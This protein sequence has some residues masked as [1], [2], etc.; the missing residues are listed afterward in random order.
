MEL[1]R[2][3]SPDEAKLILTYHDEINLS[4]GFIEGCYLTI[5]P[6]LLAMILE[7]NP[8]SKTAIKQKLEERIK[9]WNKF[10]DL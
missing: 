6:Q 10:L 3:S 8:S 1:I 4:F 5:D 9:E 7:A 2:R